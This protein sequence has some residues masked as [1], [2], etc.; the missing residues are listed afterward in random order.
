MTNRFDKPAAKERRNSNMQQ[1]LCKFCGCSRSTTACVAIECSDKHS[2]QFIV[3]NW[4]KNNGV[5]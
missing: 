3:Y 1:D 4:Q 2:P 5:Y